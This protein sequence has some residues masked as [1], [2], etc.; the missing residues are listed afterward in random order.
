MQI[1]LA[2]A[3]PVVIEEVSLPL[4]RELFDAVG[5]PPSLR[6]KSESLTHEDIL[7]ALQGDGQSDELLQAIET[8][9]DLGTPEGREAISALLAD[10]QVPAG[11]LP[12]GIGE[13]ELAL[14]LFL[15]QRSDGALAEVFTRAQV[16]VQEGN[17]RRFN[18]FIGQKPK[19]FRDLAAKRQALG[20]A[21]LAYCKQ[22]DLG[23]HVQVRVFDDEDGACRF[24]IMR[25][26]HTKTP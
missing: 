25:S 22:E 12:Q 20:Q 13:R 3:D 19:R 2:F 16:Q 9:H 5:W 7:M 23:D 10:R 14:R 11:T 21:I 24:Q 6:G 18:D 15:L 1:R 8:L 26:H 4:W 17:H